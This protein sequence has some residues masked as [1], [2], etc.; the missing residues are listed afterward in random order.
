MERLYNLKE[1]EMYQAYV[2]LDEMLSYEDFM[3]FQESTNL[4]ARWCA[5]RTSTKQLHNIGMNC[6]LTAS[7]VLEFDEETYPELIAWQDNVESIETV[8]E[9]FRSETYMEQHFISMMNYLAEQEAFLEMMGEDVV[10]YELAAEYVEANG[11]KVYGYVVM[12][13]KE[14]LIQ[15]A[16][17]N[18]EEIYQIYAVEMQ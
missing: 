1:D 5:I 4:D 8:R 6:A 18:P 3:E 2:T 17:E 10:N 13:E 14:D 9:N 7:S 15:L 11:L 12:G 16:Q